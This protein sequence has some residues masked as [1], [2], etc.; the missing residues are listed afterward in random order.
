MSFTLLTHTYSPNAG[1]T[2]AIDTT[3][4]QL[5]VAVVAQNTTASTFTDSKGN[6]WVFFSTGGNPNCNIGFCVPEPSKV[7]T[8]HTFSRSNG[9]NSAIFFACF[10]STSNR[11]IASLKASSTNTTS[12]TIQPG[13]I[14]PAVSGLALVAAAW[15]GVRSLSSIGSSF[16][17]VDSQAGV[18]GS[19]YGGC[20][21]YLAPSGTSA[22]N[23]TVTLSG[24]GSNACIQLL[25]EEIPD[26]AELIATTRTPIG[27]S[28][29]DAIDTTGANLLVV[30]SG[31][32]APA[33][34]GFS[35]SKG[36]TWNLIASPAGST[37]AL[38]YWC[39]PT[40]VGSGHTVTSKLANSTK[41]F[42]ALNIGGTPSADTS[43]SAYSA[44]ATS[45]A[46][47]S[48]TASDAGNI[49][50]VV[51]AHSANTSIK[52]ISGGVEFIDVQ[53]GATNV[54]LGAALAMLNPS[55][56]SAFNPS[57]EIFSAA[58]LATLVASFE[59]TPIPSSVVRPVP[60]FIG[61]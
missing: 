59:I 29:T 37:Y 44:S 32:T 50:L 43:A 48:I 58:N 18:A 3:G 11:F 15:N 54:T 23:P 38:L 46:S 19:T 60:I 8:G 49:T 33:L 28:T 41:I 26:P 7:G 42:A 30:A 27:N 52:S 31:A 17:T 47:G 39:A 13:S 34:T 24:S 36:N 10:S 56:G 6:A 40:S 53:P 9:L 22:L 45:L 57:A 2:S 16:A 20:L 4:A 12:S 1:T 61:L 5:L 25:I 51:A 35:D 21:G 55:G 14:T